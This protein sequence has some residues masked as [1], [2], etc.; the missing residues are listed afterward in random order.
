[1]ALVGRSCDIAE[2]R[3]TWLLCVLDLCPRTDTFVVF[4]PGYSS[5]RMDT[6]EVW[7]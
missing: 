3:L 1:M 2:C 4:M 6:T 5:E 7:L